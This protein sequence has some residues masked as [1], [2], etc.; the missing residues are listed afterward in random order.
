MCVSSVNGDM[1]LRSRGHR[2]FAEEIAAWMAAIAYAHATN[3]VVFLMSKK[4]ESLPGRV[5]ENHTRNRATPAG[6]GSP[7]AEFLRETRI[8]NPPGGKSRAGDASWGADRQSLRRSNG[9]DPAEQPSSKSSFFGLDAA[10]KSVIDDARPHAVAL[11]QRHDLPASLSA[12]T[13]RY[14]RPVDLTLRALSSKYLPRP[15]CE[16]A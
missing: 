11:C 6:D 9:E 12:G 10:I 7:A 14:H 3:G 2:Y 1:P 15:N 4:E 16:L 5:A 13:A 8:Q